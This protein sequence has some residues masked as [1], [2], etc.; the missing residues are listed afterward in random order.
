MK[1]EIQAAILTI[2]DEILYG[3]IID[4]NSSYIAEKL[5]E[6]GFSVKKKVSVGDRVHDIKTSLDT[7]LDEVD[8][9]ITTGGLG[10]TRDDMTKEAIANFLGVE[11]VLNKEALAAVTSFF[12]KRGR[13][14]TDINRHQAFLPETCKYIANKNG[15]A[16]GMWFDIKGKVLLSLPG[17]PF[18]MKA[19]LSES[20]IPELKRFFSPPV[21]THIMIRT[22]GIGESFL[23]EKISDWE[24][25]LPQN[26]SLAYLPE[27]GQVKLR[28]TVRG[29]DDLINRKQAEKECTKL[30]SLISSYVYAT[31]NISLEQ[32]LGNLLISRNLTIATAESCTGGMLAGAITSVAGS[33]AYFLGSTIAY[34]NAIKKELLGVSE[35][36]LNQ[37][38][39]VSKQTVREMATGIR[40]RMGA[41]ISIATSGIAG[42]GGGSPEKPVG[43]VWIAIADKNGIQTKKFTFGNQRAINVRLSIVAALNLVRQRILGIG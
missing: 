31:E 37:F 25:A 4:T 5:T 23:A 39:A 22:A 38:G 20:I 16:P 15:T 36:T 14:L 28:L 41:D 21:I 8:I 17:V 18:E 12:T 3:Q 40:T 43:T 2:G 33:S 1:Q 11:L 30:L 42:P 13:E 34:Q 19:L 27:P 26:I 35:D 9:L 29:E 7:L 10:P 6:A 32:A 24:Q